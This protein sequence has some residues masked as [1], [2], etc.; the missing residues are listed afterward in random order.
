MMENRGHK[1]APRLGIF[2]RVC[3]AST[4]CTSVAI[5]KCTTSWRFLLYQWMPDAVTLSIVTDKKFVV[6]E[7]VHDGAAVVLSSKE[8]SLVPIGNWLTP[9]KTIRKT[10]KLFELIPN[11]SKN[12][13]AAVAASW[14]YGI[15]IRFSMRWPSSSA[16]VALFARDAGLIHARRWPWAGAISSSIWSGTRGNRHAFLM[17][18][19]D[20]ICRCRSRPC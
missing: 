5:T 12:R 8:R 18:A 17:L 4:R 20:R 14:L 6:H 11:R 10:R 7:L 15:K 2:L 19:Q 9:P 16:A 3:L 1:V 13:F